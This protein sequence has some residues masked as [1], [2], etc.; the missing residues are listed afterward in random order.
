MLLVA[1]VREERRTQLTEAIA[2]R[3]RI[4]ISGFACRCRRSTVPAITHVDYSARVQTVDRGSPWPLLPADAALLRDHRLSDD[5]QHQL[6]HPRRAD[7]LHV[8]KMPIAAS[9]PPTWTA[10]CSKTTCC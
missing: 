5:R 1:P 8:R 2:S 3:W 10:W 7:C 6:Q 4:R 9:W